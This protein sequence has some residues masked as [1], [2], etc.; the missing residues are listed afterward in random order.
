MKRKSL[1]WNQNSWKR[2][3]RIRHKP[4]W[5]WLWLPLWVFKQILRDVRRNCLLGCL[6]IHV[7]LHHSI[8]KKARASWLEWL[9]VTV[10]MIALYKTCSERL[11]A[12]ERELP[13]SKMCKKLR[14]PH[15]RFWP[16]L[17]C[18]KWRSILNK[19]ALPC[20]KTTIMALATVVYRTRRQSRC[21]QVRQRL[22][23][24]KPTSCQLRN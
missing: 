8:C 23:A 9:M 12:I 21:S 2:W 22:V 24:I 20:K 16:H 3:S 11:L 7:N 1:N 15:I 4:I 6:L 17:R 5:A 14:S 19:V 18:F 10:M 13:G